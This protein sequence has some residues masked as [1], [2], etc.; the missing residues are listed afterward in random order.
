MRKNFHEF[1]SVGLLLTFIGGAVDLYTYTHYGAFASAQTGNL[2][3]AITQGVNGEWEGMG[4]KLLSVLFFF[5]GVVTGKFMIRYFRQKG[6]TFWRLIILY[7]EAV[8]FLL[9]S[10][11][12]VNSQT[13]FVTMAIAFVT[14]AQ[15]I[16]F[17]KINGR[18]Y[19]SLFTTGNMKGLASSLHD[20]LV[21]KEQAAFDGFIHYLLV[22]LAFII[23]AI[24][25]AFSY[26]FFHEKAII[27]VSLLFF[28]LAISQTILV[29]K[30]YRSDYE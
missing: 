18:V 4:K 28:Y 15:W 1:R 12:S 13:T 16:S 9:I 26:R 3:L 19:T 7:V 8:L 27:L 14:S 23:G 17:D 11:K 2:I 20:Y 25:S 30:F 24:C 5:I 22:V 10:F 21:T 29:L 6:W